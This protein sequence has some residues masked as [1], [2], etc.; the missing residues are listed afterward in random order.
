MPFA[1]KTASLLAAVTLLPLAAAEPI[2]PQPVTFNGPFEVEANGIRNI[3]IEFN[4]SI[5]GDLTIVYGACDMGSAAEAHHHI[6]STFVGE[7]A[8][9]KRHAEWADRRPTKFVWISPS[10][11]SSGCLHAFSNDKMVGR[12]EEFSVKRRKMKKRG[13]FAEVGDPMGPWFDGVEYLKQKQPNETFVAATKEKKF[14]IIGAGISGLM[15]A[16]C[17]VQPA[18]FESADSLLA[19]SRIRGH[20]QF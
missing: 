7:H 8:F 9:A 18:A 13:T 12:S 4:D 20:F 5:D 16:V 3:N 2:R 11:I 17:M 19:D 6:G 15:T 14:G 1:S 10:D